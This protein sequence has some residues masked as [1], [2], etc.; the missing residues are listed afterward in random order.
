M[1]V[2]VQQQTGI[3]GW[4]ATVCVGVL[5][6]DKDVMQE[7]EAYLIRRMCCSLG[8]DEQVHGH[9]YNT[10]FESNTLQQPSAVR[11]VIEL[12]AC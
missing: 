5:R 12:L 7:E 11:A 3:K 4:R 6:R 1:G 8:Q 10:S 2:G 9:G